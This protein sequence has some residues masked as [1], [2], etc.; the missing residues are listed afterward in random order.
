MN[1]SSPF[2]QG[3]L[4]H[5]PAL[6]AR[7]PRVSTLC[8]SRGNDCCTGS[9]CVKKIQV[10]ASRFI[11]DEHVYFMWHGWSIENCFR[12]MVDKANNKQ[13]LTIYTVSCVRMFGNSG[14]FFFVVK[15]LHLLQFIPGTKYNTRHRL[16]NA[17]SAW[18]FTA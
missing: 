10:F 11:Y 14:R 17:C 1:L 3:Y 4:T 9:T 7:F 5:F 8:P 18:V 12:I 16:R 6:R 2:T 13:G 15:M